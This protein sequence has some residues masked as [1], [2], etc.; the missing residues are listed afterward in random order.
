MLAGIINTI[1]DFL[2]VLLPIRTVW[3]LQLPPRQALMIMLLFA[4]GFISCG[5]GIGR[6]YYM[7]IVTQVWDKVWESYPVW[8][9]AAVELYVGMVRCLFLGTCSF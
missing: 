2:T 3:A 9:T 4:F 8:I 7:W 6:T 5:A 1:T